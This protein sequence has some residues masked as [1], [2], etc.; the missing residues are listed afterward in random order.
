MKQYT[1]AEIEELPLLVVTDTEGMI[2]HVGDP[3]AFS[4]KV[5]AEYAM[6]GFKIE[7][8]KVKE[9]NLLPKKLYQK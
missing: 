9:Y 3:T 4:K 7:T 8:M 5:L 6:S 2:I 1:D